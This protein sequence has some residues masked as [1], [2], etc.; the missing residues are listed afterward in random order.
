M[1]SGVQIHTSPFSQ[2]PASRGVRTNPCPFGAN[3][4]CVFSHV[5][6]VALADDT[7]QPW[8]GNQKLEIKV[9]SWMERDWT[10]VTATATEVVLE[11]RRSTSYCINGL[12][13]LATGFLWLIRWIPRMRGPQVDTVR[14]VATSDGRVKA[15]RK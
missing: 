15:R 5:Q 14:I 7:D 2:V 13:T 6:P 4:S 11:R 12:L 1:M 10:I 8:R 9:A 3:C